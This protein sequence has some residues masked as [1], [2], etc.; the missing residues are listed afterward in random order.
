MS[1]IPP[2]LTPTDNDARRTIPAR[3]GQAGVWVVLVL[4]A[5]LIIAVMAYSAN[6]TRVPV[7][8]PDSATQP[9]DD[10]G[11][12]PGVETETEPA[13]NPPATNP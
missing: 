13:Q 2:R 4:L 8:D 7:A 1:D 9:A 12:I 11:A 3:S 10:T 5:I 6:T